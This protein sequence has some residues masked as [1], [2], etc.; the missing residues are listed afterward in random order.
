MPISPSVDIVIYKVDNIVMKFRG[1][2]YGKI[3][4]F[5]IIVFFVDFILYSFLHIQINSVAIFMSIFLPVAAY[6][7]AVKKRDNKKRK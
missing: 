7:G 6:L 2:D 1:S 3:I 4:G 5:I